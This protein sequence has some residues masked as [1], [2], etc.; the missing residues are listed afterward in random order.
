MSRNNAQHPSD[1]AALSADRVFLLAGP[2]AVGKLSVAR[3]L[4]RRTGAIVVDNHLINNAVFLPMGMDRGRGVTLADT[5]AL[6]RR[7]LDVVLESTSLAPSGLT[8]VFTNWL[9]AEPENAAHVDRLRA[10]AE[11]RGATFVPVWMTATP[12]ALLQR[13]DAPGRA[14]RSKLTDPDILRDLLQVPSLPPP[15][16]ALILDLT[17]AG[18]EEATDQILS[19]LP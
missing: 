14:E 5:D 6:R 7:V 8:H 18:P 2:P 10:L 13:I 11:R 3:E 16:D 9:P 15:A 4:E 12:E 1:D 17:S 19:H